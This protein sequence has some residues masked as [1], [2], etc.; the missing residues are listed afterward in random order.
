VESLLDVGRIWLWALWVTDRDGRRVR[1][2]RQT[3]PM[4]KRI[5]LRKE[6]CTDGSS[7]GSP[8]KPDLKGYEIS[9]LAV[10]CV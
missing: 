8:G 9:Q 10:R 5:H 3:L 4:H 7:Y 1:L 6:I 2:R